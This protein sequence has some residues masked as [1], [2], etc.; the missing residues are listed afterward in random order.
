[1]KRYLLI[2]ALC[3]FV[4]AGSYEEAMENLNELVRQNQVRDQ[5]EETMKRLE[6]IERLQEKILSKQRDLE[7]V[8]F[9]Y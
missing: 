2:F 9:D 1:M 4:Q 7:D 8:P 3:G 5:H 6:E